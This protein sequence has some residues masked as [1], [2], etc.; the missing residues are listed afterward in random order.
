MITIFKTK[1]YKPI[2][3]DNP[4]LINEIKT[5]VSPKNLSSLYTTLA[6]L[7][8]VISDPH[9]NNKRV[10]LRYVSFIIHDGILV[11]KPYPNEPIKNM[12]LIC[13]DEKDELVAFVLK[14][15]LSPSINTIFNKF[16]KRYGVSRK[17]TIQLSYIEFVKL[18]V[19][20]IKIK[21]NDYEENVQNTISNNFINEEKQ[22]LNG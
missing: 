6:N 16:I 9:F 13:K 12:V 4:S 19:C 17:N 20:P 1:K 3:F 8:Q 15:N 18:F 10:S 11:L 14:Q 21:M 22:K 5:E 7:N 2:I